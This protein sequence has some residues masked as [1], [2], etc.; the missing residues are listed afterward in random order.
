MAQHFLNGAKVGASFEGF[1]IA[2]V[3]A[4]LGARPEECFTWGTH[5]GAELDLLVR[6]G[7]QRLLRRQQ[8]GGVGLRGPASAG[9][10]PGAEAA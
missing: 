2:Q 3:V 8:R 6:R 7:K 5:A 1:A 9:R 4:R 10:A